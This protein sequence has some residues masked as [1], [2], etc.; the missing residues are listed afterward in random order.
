[1]YVTSG[2]FELHCGDACLM[3]SYDPF[4]IPTQFKP[5]RDPFA[6]PDKDL[7]DEDYDP[8]AVQPVEDIVAAAKA[9]AEEARLAKEAHDDVDFFGGTRGHVRFN[10]TL[11][12]TTSPFVPAVNPSLLNFVDASILS[13]LELPTFDGNILEYPEF[14]SRFAT[15]VGNKVQ[16]DD[17]TK[18]SLLKSCL[19]GR[20]LHAIQGL[21][22]TPNNYK[23]AMDI[24]ATHFDDK[25]T[26]KHILY[27]KLSQLPDCDSD[28]RNLQA[29][30]NQMFALVRQ[31]SPELSTPTPEGGS[32]VTSPSHRPDAFEDD[33][34]C[35]GMDMETPTPLYDEDDSEPLT[36]FT[37]KFTG[38]GWDLMVRHPIKKKSFMAERFWKPCYVRLQ[39]QITRLVDGHITK[40]GL[41]LEHTAQ[42]T[43][44]LKFG[45]L[46]YGELQ[47][48]VA[49][50]EDVLFKCPAK[51]DTKPVYKQDEVQI[52]CYDEY[53]AYV[54]KEGILSDQKA[55]V[56]L[57]CLAFVSGS[58]FLEIGLNDR[59]RQG[60]EIVRRKDIL[61]MYTERW[62]RFEEVEFHSTVD[63]EA[64]DSE[65]VIRLSPPDGCFFEVM[66]FRIRPPRN[67]EKALTV[68][69]IM[70][71]AGSKV[72]IRIE[73]MAAAQIEKSRGGKSTRRQIPCEDI[74]IRFPIPEA[75]IYIFREERHW[76]VGSVH[77]K[78][79]RPGKVKNL[80]DRL[81]G[82]V[83]S[84]EANLIECAIGEAKYEHVYRSLVWRIPRIPEKHHAA[85]KSHLLRCR[86]ELSSFDLMPDAFLPRCEVDF[87]MPLATVSNTVVRSVSVEQH[88]DSDRVE[89]FV[90]YVAKCQYKVEIDYV[91]CADLEIDTLD[92]STNPDEAM[93]TVPELHQPAFQPAEIEQV[94]EG[95]RIEF[96]DAE[97]GRTQ[98]DDSSSDDDDDK[99]HK[100]P[101]IQIDMKNYGY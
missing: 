14:S 68:K 100:M 101:I 58:P 62:I 30:Y 80:K 81:L 97:V 56:R 94:H 27:T 40:Y 44:L 98:H 4:I 39:G 93:N 64:F 73:A 32:A 3:D 76:G 13:K 61:P 31:Q 75:W 70:K 91:Q 66:R 85:Y 6:P 49:T 25:A 33:F 71:I 5:E 57:F 54:D 8:F 86:F 10:T 51:R 87:T 2:N 65:Q 24:L 74:A 78:K 95:Y 59:R 20:A 83:Q 96:N 43:V 35:E 52:H 21:S 19:R 77:S 17:T 84:N 1:M 9:K 50:I 18:F 69:S 42:C 99:G 37:P 11:L 36:E 60:K 29:L 47:S 34:K 72:E 45:S 63:K 22:M 89:K 46:T 38:E 7:I 92:P 48:F 67:R 55:R 53:S 26:M 79:L 28:G 15:L 41:P 23:V 88:E 90:R 16:L 12:Q 82:A